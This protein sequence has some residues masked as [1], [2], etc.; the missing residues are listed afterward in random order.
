MPASLPPLPLA[1]AQ[2]MTR[3]VLISGAATSPFLARPEETDT[4]R[5]LIERARRKNDA[6]MRGE[7]E[8]WWSLVGI[9]DDFTLMQPLGG[10]ASFGFNAT[11]DRLAELSRTFR[12]GEATLEVACAYASPEMAVLVMIERQT[13][14]VGG[15]PKQDWSLR[16]TE[17]YRKAGAE[18][19]LAHRH[20]DPLVRRITLDQSA[21]L[22][23]GLTSP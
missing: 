5:T 1:P 7:M 8:R 22:A 20:A 2:P 19:R 17:V 23:R 11:P 18:W 3:R 21:A 9:S 6:F 13:G 16:V 10:P 12:N 14:E 4:V 15:L